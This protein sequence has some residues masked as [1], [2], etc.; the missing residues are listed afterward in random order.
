MYNVGARQGLINKYA[1]GRKLSGSKGDNK[2]RPPKLRSV[3][4]GCPIKDGEPTY[5]A[6]MNT[7]KLATC[8]N[9]HTFIVG[10]GPIPTNSSYL[11]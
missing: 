8:K 6:V 1:R 4:P 9:G 10:S 2:G 11:V 3:C 7:S 5:V